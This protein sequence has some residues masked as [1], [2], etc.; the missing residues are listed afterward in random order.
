MFGSIPPQ[1]DNQSGARWNPPEV[2]AIYCSLQAET[3]V[4]EGD[5]HIALQ[6]F[7]PRAERRVHRIKV[8]IPGVVLLT[9]WQLLERLGVARSSYESI[10]PARCKEIG[11][12]IAYLG[13]TGI[14]VPS[15]RCNGVNLVIYPSEDCVFEPLDFDVIA[16]EK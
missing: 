6:P 13:R 5:F 10:E 7:R 16:Y 15:A 8:N 12:A 14:L 11:G 9:D 3:A 2:P 1:K 4:A